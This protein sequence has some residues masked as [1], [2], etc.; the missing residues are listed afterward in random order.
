MTNDINPQSAQHQYATIALLA[1]LEALLG[2]TNAC[3]PVMKPIFNKLGEKR[4][5]ESLVIW[6]SKLTSGKRKLNPRSNHGYGP[7]SS[8]GN[9]ALYHNKP[10]RVMRKDSHLTFPQSPTKSE[11]YTGSSPVKSKYRLPETLWEKELQD[12]G[13]GNS[14]YA[15]EDWDV[16]QHSWDS[17]LPVDLLPQR[18]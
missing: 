8:D 17:I 11:E 15:R 2:V 10:K 6:T 3:L 7:S 1:N 16:E 5:F 12:V 4:V 13:N 18:N 9:F 14:T